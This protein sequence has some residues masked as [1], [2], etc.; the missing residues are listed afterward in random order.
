MFKKQIQKFTGKICEV[1][2][3]I[4]EKAIKIGGENVIAFY[5]F[6]GSTGNAPKVGMEILDI[7]PETWNNT[8]K[9]LYKDVAEDSAAWAKFVED[10][11]SP[12]FICLRLEGSD[13]NGLDKSVA[14][15]VKV[16]KA[17]ANAITLPLVIAGTGNHEKD[18][19]L[20][21]EVAKELEGKNVLLLSAVEDNYKTI[22]AAGVL[23]YNQKV[24]AESSVDINLAKQLNILL[25]QLGVKNESIVENVGCSAVG[26]GF[27]YVVSTIDRIKLAALG[28]DDKTLQMP[29]IT[30]VSFEVNKVKESVELESDSPEWGNQEDR[31]VSMEV[32]TAA[33]V[34]AA[35]SNA[36]VLRH[37]ASVTTIRNYLSGLLD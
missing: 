20:F 1:E 27:E 35:G 12:D 13:P 4:G 28:Q 30:P 18:A 19:K 16:A 15:T 29:I 11:F 26:Y 10:K 21:E 25:G 9:D 14:D 7:Y 37:P 36:V 24:A 2:I 8:L 32:S 22:A 34:L 17:V 6:D 31:A 23:A 33:G 3:G 5:S